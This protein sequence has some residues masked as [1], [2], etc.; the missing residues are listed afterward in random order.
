MAS[1]LADCDAMMAAAEAGGRGPERRVAAPLLPALPAD[2]ARARRG[3]ARPAGPWDRDDPRL[4]RRGLL[5][6]RPL[7]R[8]LGGRGGR[9]PREPVARTS[10]TSCSGTWGRSRRSS[11]T[12]RTSTTRP[13]RSTTRRRR[14]PLQER[15]PGQHHRQ[16]Q[17]EPGH[18]RPGVAS[19]EPTAPRSG[20]QTDGG[21]M[22]I[23]GST[24]I[25]G[26]APF[27]DIWTIPGEEGLAG[28]WRHGGRGAL[29][30]RAIPMEHFHR[31][32]VADFLA[33]RARGPARRPSPPPTAGAW[34]SCSPRSTAP[35]G[36]AGPCA[37]PSPR[38]SR[39]AG[40]HATAPPSTHVR[41][42]VA[43]ML[44]VT[45][46]INYLDRSNLSVAATGWR[47]TSSSTR[48]T[49]G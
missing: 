42:G 17:P 35:P 12:G 5:P 16:Q 33:G 21:A 39:E 25:A 27:N 37:S 32:Q 47:A 48:S 14:R 34:S 11:A 4:A 20:V 46:A 24:R 9:G 26:S 1:S 43:G 36:T 19:T 7:A 45:V 8:Q 40:P 38:S 10:W 49:W 30:R 6:Q 15:G 41:L 18:Q 28:A 44:F 22:F 3:P 13:S 23:A 31:L 29:P 2:P